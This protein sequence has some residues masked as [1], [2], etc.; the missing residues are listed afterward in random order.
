MHTRTLLGAAAILATTASTLAQGPWRQHRIESFRPVGIYNL[1]SGTAEIVD[2]ANDGRLL[3]YTDAG[4]RNLGFVDITDADAPVLVGTLAMPGEPTSVSVAGRYAFAAVWAD[5]PSEG[6]PPPAFNPGKLVVID[7]LNPA[8]PAVL[9]S[10][11][12]GFHPDSCKAR[13]IGNRYHVVVAIENQPV[14]VDG[15]GLVTDDDR[16]GS[17]N[18]VGPAGLIQV[19]AVDVGNLAA[20]VVTDVHLPAAALSAAGC[21]FP[22]DP[23]P[24]YVDWKGDRVIVSLQE[25]N[26]VAVLD[27]GNPS[28]P[29]LTRVFSTGVVLPRAADLDDNDEIDL[30]DVYPTGAP[31][32]LDAGGNPVAAGSRMPDAV[33]LTPCG[34]ALVAADEGEL[35]YTGGRGWSRWRLDGTLIGDDGG[36]LEQTAVTFSHYPDGRSDARGIEVEGIATGRFGGEDFAFV[37][38]ER[39]SFLAVY[40]IGRLARPR[41]LQILPTGIS[42]EGICVIEQRDLVVTACEVSGTINIYRGQRGPHRPSPTQPQLY[43]ADLRTPW[44]AISGLC[45]GIWPGQFF[46]VPDNALPTA[47]Y[48]IQA[49]RSFAPVTVVMPVRKNGVQARYDGEGIC[50]DRSIVRPSHA[51]FWIANEGNGSSQPNLLVQVDGHGAVVREIQLPNSIDAGADP[52]L[53]G[54]AQGPQSG[55]RIRSNGFEGL[56]LS[57]DGRYV[58][59]AIQREFAG[60]FPTGPKFARIAR[61]DLQQLQSPTVPQNGLRF[62][63]DWQFFYYEFDTNDPDNWPG[64]SEITQLGNDR[65]LVIERDKGIGAGSTLKKIYGFDLDGLTPDTDGLPDATD[66]VSKVLV[67]DVVDAF[68]PY[69]KIEGIGVSW[70]GLW[71]ALDN[72]GGE[73]ES[74]LGFF[75]WLSNLGF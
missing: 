24:E 25:N 36:D 4:N 30:G 42:P 38:S 54:T 26:G 13:R 9:G 27:L 69:E 29:Q 2:A 34:T 62:G 45:G 40:D 51:G 74:R 14:I 28:Q 21:L 31:V 16:P 71:V 10:V 52:A 58:Y 7:L 61:Y 15:N 53:G 50:L 56:C 55:G 11:D 1:P 59:A 20:S 75:G 65:F 35:S 8:A 66:T 41:L 23:Q 44:A 48:R 49:G 46:A 33:A 68:S 19:I 73:V 67:R 37:M 3:V 32:V 17:P 63:G 72:D 6:N 5:L 39:G 64:L 43:A 18:D 12:I 60:E 47:I 22:N 57:H 70:G